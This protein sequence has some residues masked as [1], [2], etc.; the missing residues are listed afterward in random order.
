M[1]ANVN[2][3]AQ[4]RW[5]IVTVS[6]VN[7]INDAMSRLGGILPIISIAVSDLVAAVISSVCPDPSI[8][9]GQP[10]L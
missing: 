4:T 2:T 6:N 10:C 7:K 3:L 5:C 1:Y 9:S 8:S